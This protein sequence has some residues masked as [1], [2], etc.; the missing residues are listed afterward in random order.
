ML[1]ALM[2]DSTGLST[3]R[4]RFPNGELGCIS[5][6]QREKN[7]LFQHHISCAPTP[8]G[9]FFAS[10]QLMSVPET[11]RHSFAQRTESQHLRVIAR[12]ESLSSATS[13]SYVCF[14]QTSSSIKQVFEY[15]GIVQKLFVLIPQNNICAQ[16][17]WYPLI[18]QI[19]TL[20]CWKV[21][22]LSG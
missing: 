13:Y 19:N 3:P 16:K 8:P 10:Q 12:P 6:W 2:L 18:A 9:Q 22:I 14:E 1:D 20:W 21:S 4:N 5:A 15:Q 7:A 17:G 11:S